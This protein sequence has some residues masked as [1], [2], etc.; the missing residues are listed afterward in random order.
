[1]DGDAASATEQIVERF[2]GIRPMAA[3][4]DTPVTTVQGWKKRGIIPQSR[5][6]DI[7]AAAT[8]EGITLEPDL[9]AQT[10][11][12]PSS[13]PEARP[14]EPGSA[15]RPEPVV[16]ARRS[17]LAGFAL[18][19]SLIVLVGVIA[20]AT[21]AWVLFLEPLKARVASLEGRSAP[22]SDE[23]LDHRIT[24]LESQLAALS[25]RPATAQP[26]ASSA[27]APSGAPGADQLAQIEQQLAELK[28]GAAETEQLAKRLSDLQI[29]AGG[30]E[31]L[32]QSIRDIQSS[33]AAAQGEVERLSTQVGQLGSR[34]DRAEAAL[35]DRRQQGLKAEAVVLGVTELGHA[36][37]TSKPFAKD[38]AALRALVGGNTDMV[39]QLDQ[40]QPFA[41]DG[42]PTLD[43]LR[44]DF[45][46]QAPAIVRSAVIG[47]GSKWWR[48]ALYH[49]ESVISVRRTGEDVQGNGTDAIVA[50]AET[51]LDEDDL[52]GALAALQAL[53]GVPAQTAQPW[54][55]DAEH[56]LAVDAT[57]AELTRL[58]IAQLA[59]NSQ[60]P[61][62]LTQPA[63]TQPAAA[64]AT[65][66]QPPSPQPPP[67]A[68]PGQ[69]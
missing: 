9:L 17:R 20:G 12:G 18:G 1:M 27:A 44:T 29:A 62:A 39:A 7:L 32:A 35:A 69:P 26:A 68:P 57:Q 15:P 28:S 8:R 60:V 16:V 66:A 34:L 5:H 14:A 36:L 23:A 42:V 19:L 43:D 49:V 22:A 56:R 46:R 52:K 31:L 24:A 2:G 53:D 64:Q 48:Q 25:S 40:L 58:A 30:R 3:K 13:R 45:G 4:L 54:I 65:T 41:D 6:P 51:K 67:V 33:T 10:D 50:R 55:H 59:G 38:L 21:A 37:R 61:G 47:D 63:P 11:P